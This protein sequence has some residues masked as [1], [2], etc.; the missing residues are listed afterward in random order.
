MQCQPAGDWHP[1]RGPLTRKKNRTADRVTIDS[2]PPVAMIDQSPP[3]KD[4]RGLRGL[5][6]KTTKAG[7]THGS[8]SPV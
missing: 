8:A 1:V 3:G 7:G 6:G 2:F 5:Q 4:S